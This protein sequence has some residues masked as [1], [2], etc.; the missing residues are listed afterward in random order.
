MRYLRVGSGDVALIDSLDSNLS[1]P[2]GE[3]PSESHRPGVEDAISTLIADL[4]AADDS[5]A[6]DYVPPLPTTEAV[7]QG[8]VESDDDDGTWPCVPLLGWLWIA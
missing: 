7:E 6:D 8:G 3:S 5:D 4:Q 2:A 1:L